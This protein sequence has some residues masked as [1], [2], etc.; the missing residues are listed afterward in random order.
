MADFPVPLAQGLMVP[1]IPNLWNPLFAYANTTTQAWGAGLMKMTRAI[2]PM[3]IKTVQVEVTGAS[4]SN[5]RVGV[6]ADT[7]T[8]PGQLLY[9][10]ADI[11]GAVAV[12]L[13]AALAVPAGA[14]WFG[15]QNL[16][17]SSLTLRAVQGMS[18]FLPGLDVPGANNIPNAWNYGAG[19]GA[20]LPVTPPSGALTRSGLC[21]LLFVQAA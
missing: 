14:Y 13:T 16:G 1:T 12:A 3:A 8:G 7:P 19:N 18:P 11:A 17:A 20:V 5:L 15:V 9:Q 6:W 10:T 21:A 2:L 4:S